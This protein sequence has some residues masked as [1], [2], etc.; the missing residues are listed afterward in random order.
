MT[1]SKYTAESQSDTRAAFGSVTDEKSTLEGFLFHSR[2]LRRTV[3]V[4]HRVYFIPLIYFCLQ[5]Q[6]GEEFFY[7]CFPCFTC[8]EVDCL[9]PAMHATDIVHTFAEVG[10]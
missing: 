4:A 3:F 5:Q 2:R 9:L 10:K 8:D 7:S 1:L 6:P